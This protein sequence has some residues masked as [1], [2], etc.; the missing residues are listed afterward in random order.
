MV[1]GVQEKSTAGATTATSS[2][3]DRLIAEAAKLFAKK[4][5]GGVSVREIC[6]AAG[7]SVN[8]INHYFGSKDGLL[9]AVLSRFDDN[10][11]AVPLRL[12]QTPVVSK[13]DLSARLL[14]VFETTL[15]ACLAERD[16]MMVALNE[17]TPLSTLDA[18]QTRFV[19]LLE[20]AKS[21][22]YVRAELN[23]Q[24]VSGAMLDRV[25]AQAQHTPWILAAH[26]IDVANDAAYRREWCQANIDLFLRGI[27]ER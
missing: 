16:V 22:G 11:Y 15:E 5:F 7:T 19:E 13:E 24:M 6:A 21:N 2:P 25:I 9:Q 12:L 18:F 8:M 27:L 26:G 10:V 4:S 17:Q 20:D 23:C 14:I 1:Q 3:R